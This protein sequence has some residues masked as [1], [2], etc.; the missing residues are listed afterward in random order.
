MQPQILPVSPEGMGAEAGGSY[1]GGFQAWTLTHFHLF[2]G[3]EGLSSMCVGRGGSFLGR[4]WCWA[5]AGALLWGGERGPSL[6]LFEDSALA[7]G[8]A[9]AACT[10][11]SRGCT[12]IQLLSSLSHSVSR[13]AGVFSTVVFSWLPA[14]VA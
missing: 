13:L 1:P 11:P 4:R 2:S 8:V 7:M 6:L 5:P 12:L 9:A 10:I 3:W 14:Q